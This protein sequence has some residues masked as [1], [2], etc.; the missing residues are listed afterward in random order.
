VILQKSIDEGVVPD[1]WKLANVCPIFK[2]GS[3]SQAANYRPVSLTS[4]VC[5]LF[6]TIIRAAVHGRALGEKLP[7]K[8][9]STRIQKW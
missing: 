2:K 1:D 7:N 3:R 9:F 5:K 4:Q 8:G 6:E